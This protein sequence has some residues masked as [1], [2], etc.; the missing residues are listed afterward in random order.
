V[1][2]NVHANLHECFLPMAPCVLEGMY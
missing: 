2:G 1:C